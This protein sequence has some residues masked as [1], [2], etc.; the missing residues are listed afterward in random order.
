MR[1]RDTRN[2]DST[3]EF[4]ENKAKE[5]FVEDFKDR[6][7]FMFYDFP[8]IF[9]TRDPSGMDWLALCV[10]DGISDESGDDEEWFLY[11]Q[12]SPKALEDFAS[13]QIPVRDSI[14]SADQY[15]LAKNSL[16]STKTFPIVREDI[17]EEWLPQKGI[18]LHPKG[19]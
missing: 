4:Y 2:S 18:F 13:D 19:D 7:V 3:S 10:F 12:M 1:D 11:C 6:E 9:S 16:R 15:L 14:L 8:R 5:Y 17:V